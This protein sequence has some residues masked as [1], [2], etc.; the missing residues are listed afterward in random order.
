LVDLCFSPGILGA[1]IA[2]ANGV[3]PF[4]GGL[5]VEKSTWRWVFWM[6]PL[7]ATPAAIAILVFLPLKHKPGN[8][9]AK[10]RMIDYGGIAL[11]VAAC[12]LILIPLSGGGLTYAWDSPLVISMLTV[13]SLMFVA[14]VLY[15]WKLAP[16]PIMPREHS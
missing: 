11:N 15:E 4:I 16:V 12:L 10:V 3:G 13:G 14:F 8:Y 7:A 2:I 1:I 6:V 9:K 5:V